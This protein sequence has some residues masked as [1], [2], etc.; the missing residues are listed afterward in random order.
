M[1]VKHEM[2]N[3]NTAVINPQLSVQAR[4]CN[5]ISKSKYPLNIECLSN[6]VLYKAN[7]CF[8]KQRQ[9]EIGKKASKC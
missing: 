7:T 8:Y 9:T 5:C 1:Y 2:K 6:N 4:T 3:H